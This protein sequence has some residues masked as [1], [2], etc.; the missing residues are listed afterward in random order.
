ML[1]IGRKRSVPVLAEEPAG[2]DVT[3]FRDPYVAEWVSMDRMRRTSSTLYGI[4]SGG[5]HGL[6]PR[7]YLYAIDPQ[8]LTAWT[9]LH[10]LTTD[11]PVNHTPSPRWSGDFGTNWECSNF[12]TLQD[13]N[14]KAYEVFIAGSEGGK[15]QDWVKKHYEANPKNVRRVPRYSNWTMGQLVKQNDETRLEIRQAGLLDCGIFY[16]ATTFVTPDGRRVAWGWM[17]EEDLPD[18]EL[19]KKRWTGCFGLPRQLFI[20]TVT[21]VM[22]GLHSDLE[23]IGSVDAMVSPS[24]FTVNTLG[25]RPLADLAALKDCI[26]YDHSPSPLKDFRSCLQAAPL[27]C[28]IEAT[29]HVFDKTQSVSLIVRHSTDMKIATTVTFDCRDERLVIDRSRSTH[30]QDINTAP[31]VGS[32]TLYRIA[33]NSSR[34]GISEALKLTAFIDHD[35]IEVFA[36]DRLAI[37]TR[38]YT[39]ARHAGISLGSIGG[40]WVEKLTIWQMR[41]VRGSG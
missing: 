29:L 1:T 32:H 26:L 5:Q 35:V 4:I 13:G 24:G 9:Y 10:P 14:G 39:D 21:N 33:D 7:S 40:G 34:S 6:G 16:A 31:E 3:G 41:G 25:V 20:Q 28:A 37:S 23:T 8:D 27:A 19:K 12:F 30:R 38:V 22:G 15:E 2:L 17:I 11:L 18:T 36:N